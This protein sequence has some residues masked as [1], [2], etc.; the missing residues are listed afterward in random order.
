MWPITHSSEEVERGNLSI[1]GLGLMLM[2]FYCKS[3]LDSFF[4]RDENNFA[5]QPIAHSQFQNYS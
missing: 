5:S 2:Y 3:Q 4:L 1:A